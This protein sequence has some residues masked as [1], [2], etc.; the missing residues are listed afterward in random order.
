LVWDLRY[1]G[2]ERAPGEGGGGGGGGGFGG[3]ARGPLVVPGEY[4]VTLEA[5]GQKLQTRVTVE[6]DPRVDIPREHYVAQRDAALQVRDLISQVNRMLVTMESVEQQVRGLMGSSRSTAAAD[7]DGN[8]GRGDELEEACKA[9]LKEIEAFKDRATR[10]PPRM[11]YRQAPRVREE[12]Q[13]L[14]GAMSEV[15]SRPTEGE[16]VRLGEL[17]AET[18]ALQGS[19]NRLVETSIGKINQLAGSR[20]RIAAPGD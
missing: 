12:L 17:K 11:G 14:M 1:A 16:M 15:A 20:P 13:T 3:G 4:T 18:E 6:A 10:P 5:A 7:G 8:G 19:W 9:A 2:P